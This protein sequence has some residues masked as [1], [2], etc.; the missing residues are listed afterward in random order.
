MIWFEIVGL[1]FIGYFLEKTYYLLLEWKNEWTEKTTNP[2]L[3]DYP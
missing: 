2:N 1:I 3:E